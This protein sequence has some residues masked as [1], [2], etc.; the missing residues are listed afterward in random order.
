[1]HSRIHAIISYSF[2]N[3]IITF[4]APSNHPSYS[5]KSLKIISKKSQQ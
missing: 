5:T 1:M 2:K 3:K 4:H